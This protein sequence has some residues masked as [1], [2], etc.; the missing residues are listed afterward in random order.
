MNSSLKTS[1]S[2]KN[3]KTGARHAPLPQSQNHCSGSSTQI[4]RSHTHDNEA[5]L[6]DHAVHA[7]KKQDIAVEWHLEVSREAGSCIRKR[8]EYMRVNL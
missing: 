4:T 5:P 3:Q 6:L 8:H 7:Q 1:Q 2:K